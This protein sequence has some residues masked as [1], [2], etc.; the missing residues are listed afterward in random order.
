[1]VQSRK[2]KN[3]LTVEE[4]ETRIT[5]QKILESLEAKKYLKVEEAYVENDI[6]I[7]HMTKLYTRARNIR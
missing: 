3:Y 1:M 5:I 2:G 6:S 7:S 4:P